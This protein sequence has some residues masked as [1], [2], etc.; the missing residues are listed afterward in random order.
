MSG[1]SRGAGFVGGGGGVQRSKIQVLQRPCKITGQVTT[2]GMCQGQRT[3]SLGAEAGGPGPSAVPS[4]EKCS[5]TGE[6]I[7]GSRIG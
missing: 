2:S 4:G 6:G 5:H 3:P 7:I 1:A